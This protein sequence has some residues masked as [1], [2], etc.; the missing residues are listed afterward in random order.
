P[1]HTAPR[2][3]Q[4]RASLPRI[5]GGSRVPR[6]ARPGRRGPAWRGRRPRFALSTSRALADAARPEHESELVAQD[7]LAGLDPSLQ[8]QVVLVQIAVRTT[9]QV[10]A[11][12]AAA[13]GDRV[14]EVAHPMC[15]HAP[16]ETQILALQ[17][18]VLRWGARRRRALRC[19][20]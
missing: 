13:P 19:R 2:M 3:R 5:L 15:A 6:P 17:L 14:G 4:W 11:G 9:L 10:E 1:P 18:L 8:S 20:R 12:M 7:V 16:R